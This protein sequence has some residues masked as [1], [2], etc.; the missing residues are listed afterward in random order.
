MIQILDKIGRDQRAPSPHQIPYG[1]AVNAINKVTDLMHRMGTGGSYECKQAR[2]AITCG[3][4]DVNGNNDIVN[5]KLLKKILPHKDDKCRKQ[6]INDCISY[7]DK[8][9]KG[10]SDTIFNK[11]HDLHR[12]S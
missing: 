9:T 6:W 7:L 2:Q 11:Y 4:I 5:M 3:V 10:E 8:Y 12:D 1:S